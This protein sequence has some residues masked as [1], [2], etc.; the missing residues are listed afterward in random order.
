[1]SANSFPAILL[2]ELYHGKEILTA[3]IVTFSAWLDGEARFDARLALRADW[4]KI[5]DI[6]P[7]GSKTARRR[8][9]FAV[10]LKSDQ[11]DVRLS[12]NVSS[13]R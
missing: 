1:M 12:S 13:K 3:P 2:L 7:I 9:D 5:G 4:R 6:Y 8:F 11:G 10:P